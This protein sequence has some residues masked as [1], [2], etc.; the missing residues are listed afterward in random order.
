MEITQ[1]VVFPGSTVAG[2]EEGVC[3]G[4]QDVKELAADVQ[5]GGPGK[6]GA[7]YFDDGSRSK[8]SAKDQMEFG[9]I[10]IGSINCSAF[11]GLRWCDDVSMWPTFSFKL[12]FVV[13]LSFVSS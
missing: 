13:V 10:R 3:S 5:A 9:F 6:G 11:G 8:L 7:V 4:G 1:F 2:D 12:M